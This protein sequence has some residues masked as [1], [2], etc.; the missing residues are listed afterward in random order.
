MLNSST[1]TDGAAAGSSNTDVPIATM[2]K[3]HEGAT[4]V[5]AAA[6]REGDTTG[7]FALRGLE[8]KQTAEVLGEDR[9]IEVEDGWF[10]DGFGPYDVHIYRVR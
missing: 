1:I 4:Y 7:T 3:R 9:T 2:V 10:E 6:M 5:F 8:G